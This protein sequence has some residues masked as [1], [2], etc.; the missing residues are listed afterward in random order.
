MAKKT[1]VKGG[2]KDWK[3]NRPKSTPKT[4]TKKK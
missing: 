1:R 2:E 3:N 4:Y